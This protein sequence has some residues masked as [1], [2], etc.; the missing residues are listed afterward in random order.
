[1][2]KEKFSSKNKLVM[3]DRWIDRWVDGGMEGWINRQID[4]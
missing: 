1:M 4:G 2:V 3:W